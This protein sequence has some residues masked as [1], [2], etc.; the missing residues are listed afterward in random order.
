MSQP[1]PP[2]FEIRTARINGSAYVTV[3]GELDIATADQL[4]AVLS[5][6]AANGGMLVLDIGGLEFIDSTGIR[7]LVVAWNESQRDGFNLRLTRGSDTV[8]RAFELVG[9]LHELPFLGRY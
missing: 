4:H 1:L 7:V 8:M 3:R 5:E 6:E 2:Q 9:L